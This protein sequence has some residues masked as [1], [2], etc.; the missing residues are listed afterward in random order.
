[1]QFLEYHTLVRLYSHTDLKKTPAVYENKRLGKNNGKNT[2][3]SV[4][5]NNLLKDYIL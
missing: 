5:W 1:M 4:L 2:F 3:F